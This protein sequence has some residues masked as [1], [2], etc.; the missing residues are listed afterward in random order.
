MSAKLWLGKPDR[1]ARLRR[2]EALDLND[3][4]REITM[5]FYGD[6]QSVML[7]KSFNGFMFTFGAPRMSRILSSTARLSTTLQSES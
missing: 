4:Y 7:L 6:F 2:I 3:N 5:L 1:H